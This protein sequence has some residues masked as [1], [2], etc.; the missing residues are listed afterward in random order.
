[1]PSHQGYSGSASSPGLSDP[2]GLVGLEIGDFEVIREIGRG[3]MG[4]VFQARQ[5]SL[6]RMVALKVLSSGL[7]L[8]PTTVLRFQREAQAAAQLHHDNI[9]PIHA[10]GE[11]DGVYYYAMELIQ[12]E[13][14]HDL[15]CRAR[16]C[17]ADSSTDLEE[18]KPLPTQD[19]QNDPAAT[20][21]LSSA[22]RHQP[23]DSVSVSD[24]ALSRGAPVQATQFEKI[25][26]L[27]ADVADA[28]DY[29]HRRGVIHRDVK[30]HNLI[31][32]EE[33]RI[34]VLDF[35]LARV[36]AQPG[37]T[38]TGEFVG[39][40]LYMSPEQIVGGRRK[41]DQRTDTY[42]LGATL[43]EWL[44]LS[45]PHPGETREQVISKIITAEMPA[46]RT[47]NSHIPLDL[48]TICLKA[49]EKDSDRRYRSSGEFR[50]DLRRFVEH[51]AIRAKR[52]GILTR[53]RKMVQ[54][55]KVACITVAAVVVAVGLTFALV[56]Q[57]SQ[58]RNRENE[59][60]TIARTTEQLHEAV[61]AKD[62]EL[63]ESESRFNDLQAMMILGD[64]FG[65]QLKESV[66][67]AGEFFGSMAGGGPEMSGL[68]ERMSGVFI[69]S[70]RRDKPARF[71]V[72]LGPGQG[73]VYEL[74]ARALAAEDPAR[75]IRLVNKCLFLDPQHLGAGI[76]AAALCCAEQDQV[77][78]FKHAGAVVKRHPGQPEGYLLSGVANLLAGDW[79][80]S[81]ANFSAVLKLDEENSW[82]LALRGVGYRHQ[83]DYAHALAD[84]NHA[85]QVD[86][87]NVVALLERGRATV[88]LTKNY[89]AGIA[90][91]THIIELEP[92]NSEAYILRG[93]CHDALGRYRESSKDYAR[94]NKLV[95]GSL[96]VATKLWQA[97][98][99]RQM[100]EAVIEG[101][102]TSETSSKP[103]TPFSASE[104]T[105][106]AGTDAEKPDDW[107]ERVLE[108]QRG[109]L[110]QPSRASVQL[111]RIFA[112]AQ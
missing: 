100:Q 27:I 88:F 49:L 1:M 32:G 4:T 45:P 93:D 85:L 48:E 26:R 66:P 111:R 33:G 43:Y 57:T 6:N 34:Y 108:Q 98:A 72:G 15:I 76:L 23:G 73:A 17:A 71:E 87:G 59:F 9:V 8:T 12:G 14:L 84:F 69:D 38:T 70:L 56:R 42:S 94:A 68:A 60:A 7:G 80:A 67:K 18:T 103:S 83:S 65:Q 29:A 79:A 16:G 105:P 96:L 30:P 50:D 82:A 19:D 39:S 101:A 20:V 61:K 74:Y 13:N 99:K 75:A 112:G 53:A 41:V 86:P 31:L 35:G 28:L 40:P 36:L 5:K 47:L 95:P 37:V 92:G 104:A 54:H 10:Q 102:D 107:L 91:A 24:P 62:K 89:E 109:N 110:S 81:T 55:N 46:P 2:G 52:A 21:S 11:S 22:S 90:D 58:S 64:K 106:D 78:M 3:G 44:T 77:R 63:A 97:T 25:A 51:E